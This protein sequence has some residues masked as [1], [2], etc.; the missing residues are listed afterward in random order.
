MITL[1]SLSPSRAAILRASGVAFEVAA[2]GVNEAAVKA[3]LLEQGCGPR[4]IAVALAD[5]KA[6]AVSA[7]REGLVIGADQ[8][9]DLS[10][11]LM[12][13]A[14]DLAGARRHLERL[15]GRTHVLHAAVTLA[16]GG[17]ALWRCVSSPRLHVRAA[18]EAFL[19]NYL[20]SEGSSVLGSV[21]CY[22]LEGSGAQLMER[23]E[24]DYFSVLGL[25]LI[26]LLSALRAHG[27]LTA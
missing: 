24:G 20:A 9:L 13:K 12:D 26:E 21:G 11:E 19:D 10:G 16:R 14:D 25:P 18:S 4:G 17:A 23:V 8:T 22:H 15:V 7:R 5:E 6:L 3:R 1:A 2:S 27:A